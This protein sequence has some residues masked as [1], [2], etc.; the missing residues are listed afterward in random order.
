MSRL[1]KLPIELPNG[2]QA[3]LEDDF[4]IVK[5]PKGEL[6]IKNNK[7]VKIEIKDSI[8]SV[9]V[10]NPDN[11]K[12]K[13][14]WGLYRSLINNMVIGVNEGFEK[15]LEINGVGYRV[16][17]AGKNLVLN[18]GYSH[19]VEY[20]IPEGININ[21][22]DKIITVTGIDKKLVGEVAAQIRMVKKPEPYKGKGIKYLDEVIRRKEGK[23]AVKSE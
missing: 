9:S 2:T 11:K 12:E 10:K 22:E 6:K 23:S 5:G 20:K 8:I 7:F 3:K 4:I 13:S 1:G 14:L 16:N 15:K 17:V 21:V 18:V 19:P